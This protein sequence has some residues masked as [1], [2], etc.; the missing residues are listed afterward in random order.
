MPTFKGQADSYWGLIQLVTKLKPG[1]IYHL[2]NLGAL[3]SDRRCL[4][5]GNGTTK[6]GGQHIC[7]QHGLQTLV[8]PLL[9]LTAPKKRFL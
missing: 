5:S 4:C 3:Q 9:T 6:P 7:L 2:E 1:P 8:S